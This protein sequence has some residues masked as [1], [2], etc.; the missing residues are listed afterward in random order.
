MAERVVDVLEVIEIETQDRKL[1]AAFGKPQ[2]LFELL[3]EQRPVR[4]V[5]QRVMARHVGNLFLGGLPFRDV[6]KGRDPSA[7]FMG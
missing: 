1:I 4:Q 6:F 5:G 3:A 7:P 2:S